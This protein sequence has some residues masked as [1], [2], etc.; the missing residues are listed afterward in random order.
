MHFGM[1]TYVVRYRI[2][3]MKKDQ[4]TLDIGILDG[5][6]PDMTTQT[7]LEVNQCD[8]CRVRAPLTD[9]GH[10]KMPDGGYMGCTKDRYTVDT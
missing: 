8:G 10:H 2:I 1:V 4:L 3:P 5:M 7:W 6:K 9:L